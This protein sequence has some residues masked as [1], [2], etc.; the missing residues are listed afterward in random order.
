[1]REDHGAPLDSLS[2]FTSAGHEHWRLLL[3]TSFADRLH[4]WR[5]NSLETEVSCGA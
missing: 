2:C 4:H 3:R 1:V 5:A